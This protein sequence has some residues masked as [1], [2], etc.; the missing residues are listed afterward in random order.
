MK[1]KLSTI[2]VSMLFITITLSI[3]AQ[4]GS[5][6]DP[7]ILDELDEESVEYLDI[8]SA[9]FFEKEDEPQ[10]LFISLKLNEITPYRLKQHLSVH[11]EY[12][13]E[14]CAA[15]LVIGYGKPW[16]F[17]HAGYGHG[18]CFQ[19]FYEEIEGDYNEESGI[20][21]YKIPKEIINNPQKGEVLT[22]TKAETFQRWGFIGRLGFN[23]FWVFA[24]YSLSTGKV[25]F[26]AAPYEYGRD[27]IIQY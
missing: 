17:Y 27:Y 6:E 1:N 5:E 26:D 9:W 4:A 8:I 21:T 12:N 15:G 11:W 14:F 22:K 3:T 7:E 19:E 23:R 20:I 18:W 16:F 25:P 2:F 10:Y 24:L 13:G